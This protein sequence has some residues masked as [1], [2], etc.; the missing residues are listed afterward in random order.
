[1]TASSYLFFS[2]INAVY[3]TLAEKNYANIE[4]LLAQPVEQEVRNWQ[5]LLELLVDRL[6]DHYRADPDLAKLVYSNKIAM[7]VRLSERSYDY[8]YAQI[9]LDLFQQYFI[10]PPG[11]DWAKTFF[12][13]TEI[14]DTILTLSF[15]EHNCLVPEMT[16]EA[17]RAAIAYLKLYVGEYPS[18][19]QP[20]PV[21]EISKA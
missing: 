18:R 9:T 11:R 1:M 17:K 2:D 15:L 4:N 6:V 20:R 5:R 19:Q 10:L 16:E 13:A 14:V 21:A 8:N 12:V 7:E 3:I